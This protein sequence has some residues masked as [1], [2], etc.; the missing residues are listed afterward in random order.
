[1]SL[2]LRQR[3]R[4]RTSQPQFPVGI[5]WSNP[6][7]QG[8]EFA[9]V[10]GILLNLVNGSPGAIV[11]TVTAPSGHRGRAWT[12][13][14]DGS[15]HR[16]DFSSGVKA[17]PTEASY[18]SI[19]NF[20]YNGGT[21]FQYLIMKNLAGID[22]AVPTMIFGIPAL[23]SNDNR[24]QVS[25]GDA[26]FVRSNENIP[27]GAWLV[28]SG[29]SP[30]AGESTTAKLFLNGSKLTKAGASVDDTNNAST[31]TVLR[32]NGRHTDAGRVLTGGQA[33]SVV[34]NRVLSDKEH[35]EWAANP[36]QVF[37]PIERRIWVPVSGGAAAL[38][39]SAAGQA[40]APGTLTTGIPLMGAAAA[41]ATGPGSLDAQ[42][43][44]EGEATGQAAA[45][46]DLSTGIPL[47]GAADGQ[48]TA[49][50]AFA[51]TISDNYERSSVKLADSSITGVGDSA[52]ISIKPRLQSSEVTGEARWLEPSARVDGVAGFRPT[53]R[54]SSYL[55]SGAGSYHGQ[56][57]QSTR[58]PMFSYDR[59]TWTYFDTPVTIVNGS[60]IEFRHSTAFTQDTVY[61]SRSRQMSVA[62]VGAWIAAL[63]AAHPT[64]IEPT[65]TAASFTP[66][67]T[68]WPAQSFIADEYSAQ[69]NELGGTIPATP[70]YA[71]QINDTSLMPAGGVAK[72]LAEVFCGVHAG[73]DHANYVLKAFADAVLASTT[74]G[75]NLRRNYIIR[76]CPMDNAPARDGGGW[77]GS[78]TLGTGGIDDANRH[79]SD[80]NPGLEIIVKPRT[81]MA[82]DRGAMI[83][84][85]F[86][87]FHSTPWQKWALTVSASEPLHATA[88]SRLAT[89][90]GQTIA[91]DGDPPAGSW[92]TYYYNTVG[93]VFAIHSETGDP[94]MV[95]D[96]EIATH[97]DALVRTIDSMFV[98]LV[99][100]ATAAASAS[101]Q[102]AGG[103][104]Q[105]AGA[106]QDQAFAVA[107]LTTA[108]QLA[109]AALAVPGASGT[110]IAGI[111]LDGSAISVSGAPAALT[112]QIRLD[113]AALGLAAAAA[114]FYDQAALQGAAAGQAAAPATLTVE[115]RLLGAAQGQAAA[116]AT[117]TTRIDLS[118]A[119]IAQAVAQGYLVQEVPL[120]GVALASASAA[121]GLAGGGAA[122]VWMVS[123][124]RRLTTMTSTVSR[125]PH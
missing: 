16:I 37:R 73:E 112:A 110:L 30:G 118:A 63:A 41:Q 31:G 27:Q 52:V 18:G 50:A 74:W 87:D 15:N 21:T 109:G 35:R 53:F 48:A 97:A 72:R 67:L 51:I 14:Y 113:G 56:P 94:S 44:L 86:I 26:G 59:E 66:T 22:G 12:T 46:G 4:V 65:P 42:A 107:D 91:D 75:E 95:S 123:S 9:N 25:F 98:Q 36:W 116:P 99:G 90:S 82:D 8:L 103:A 108:I 79:A 1:M 55:T 34:W 101:A 61:I 96:A 78:F 28:G 6:L 120:F 114:G 54:F 11:G 2:L 122:P 115:I 10:G 106:G 88:L 13:A 76:F 57:W 45:P 89:Y 7:T 77:R 70:L 60:H 85:W 23:A 111:P 92:A 32:L 38:E 47:A 124:A 81:A 62:Q 43:Q 71:F 49:A 84:D 80:A 119:A 17:P 105:L 69:T 117:L 29:S 39:G 83:P 3:P 125:A 19:F 24:L 33:L 104:A 40:A 121:A 68:T 102:L 20:T 5:D 100:A 93:A 58:R 64:I